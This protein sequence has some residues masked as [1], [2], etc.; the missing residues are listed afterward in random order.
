[1]AGDGFPAF[2]E[3]NFESEV[4]AREGLTVVD[5]WAEWCVPCKQMTKVLG[6]LAPDLPGDV[7]IGKV[8]ADEN[9]GLMERYG[10]KGIPTLLFFKGGELVESRTGVDR[11]Q[12]IRK[13][14]EAHL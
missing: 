7:R 6:R 2:D 1:M 3:A 12:V 10:V 9:P 11:P 5:F 8:N 14:I 4:I 13:A